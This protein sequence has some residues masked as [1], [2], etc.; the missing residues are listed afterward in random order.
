MMDTT[1]FMGWY[2]L[3]DYTSPHNS[4]PV[5]VDRIEDGIAYYYRMEPRRD[6]VRTYRGNIPLNQLAPAK[7]PRPRVVCLCGSTRFY[8]TFQEANLNETMAGRIVLTIGCDTKSDN[9]LFKEWSPEKLTGL[10]QRL[11][12]LHLRKIDLAD[13]ILVLNVGQY[14]G[15]STWREVQYA[16]ETGKHIRYWE[17]PTLCGHSPDRIVTT[18]EGLYCLDCENGA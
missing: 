10:K 4:Y 8:E 13:E 6:N 1:D 15:E 14:I 7:P 5:F 16:L 17:T 18:E 11:D 3:D 2:W 12:R 9:D